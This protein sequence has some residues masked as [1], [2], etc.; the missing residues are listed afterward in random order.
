MKTHVLAFARFVALSSLWG[1]LVAC[2]KG[3]SEE[4][5]AQAASG[6]PPP[7]ALDSLSKKGDPPIVSLTEKRIVGIAQ[8]IHK[9]ERA[10]ARIASERAVDDR[11][12]TYADDTSRAHASAAAEL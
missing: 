11:A 6:T 7:A 4:P 3:E 8:A 5:A 1:G 2:G 10:L 9:S 12:R